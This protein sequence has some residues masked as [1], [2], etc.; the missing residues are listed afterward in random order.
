VSQ[1]LNVVDCVTSV[2]NRMISLANGVRQTCPTFLFEIGFNPAPLSV[3]APAGQFLADRRRKRNIRRLPP[4]R[5]GE[6][7]PDENTS[8]KGLCADTNPTE[9]VT[10]RSDWE[11]NQRPSIVFVGVTG[12]CCSRCTIVQAHR[13]CVLICV[14][15]ERRHCGPGDV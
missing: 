2:A 12:S 6:K 4:R 14:N 10:A 3:R 9:I 15:R 5:A 8:S 1:K 11:S 7:P 13:Y